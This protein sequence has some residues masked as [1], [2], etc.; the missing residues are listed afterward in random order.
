MAANFNGQHHRIA[1]KGL[2]SISQLAYLPSEK[3]SVH[4]G[5]KRRRSAESLPTYATIPTKGSEAPRG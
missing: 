2:P 5:K 3:A 1:S 4:C